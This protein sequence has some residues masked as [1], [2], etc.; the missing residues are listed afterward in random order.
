MAPGGA[1]FARPSRLHGRNERLLSD[2]L[3]LLSPTIAEGIRFEE[4]MS[5]LGGVTVLPR[6]P[7]LHGV[8]SAERKIVLGQ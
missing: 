5:S 8:R 4:T 1:P 7:N 2:C 6:V 3:L